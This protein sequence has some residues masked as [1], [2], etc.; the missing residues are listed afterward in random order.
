MSI[1][2]EIIGNALVCTDTLTSEI[3]LS[4]PS[5]IVWY[6]ENEL[7]DIDR[8]SFYNTN[9]VFGI[10]INS[11]EF[12]YID[13]LNAV[14]SSLTPFTKNSIRSFIQASLGAGTGFLLESENGFLLQED[15]SRI[16]L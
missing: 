11:I 16:I 1:K 5:D 13:F 7:E 12:P 3:L 14:D 10:S 9:Y 6:K 8:I 2:I 4:Q 15:G